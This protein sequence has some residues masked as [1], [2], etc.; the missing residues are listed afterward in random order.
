MDFMQHSTTTG[1]GFRVFVVIDEFT[2]EL[3]AL[4][5]AFSFHSLK[6]IEVLEDVVRDHG[7][8]TAIRSDNGPEFISKLTVAWFKR[9]GIDHRRSRPGKPVDNAICESTNGR[10]RDELLNPTLFADLD[11]AQD[12]LAT[13]RHDFNHNRP[14]SSLDQR[15]PASYAQH[16]RA[17]MQSGSAM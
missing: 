8:P 10:I 3:V 14:H 11:E 12:Q 17:I 7:R 2:R 15:T 16:V 5:A 1:R 6:V 4:R 9:A 13:Y